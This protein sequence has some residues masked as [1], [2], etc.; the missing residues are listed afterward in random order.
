MAD[1]TTLSVPGAKF[2]VPRP[3]KRMVQVL[4]AVALTSVLVLVVLSINSMLVGKGT[5]LQGFNAWMTFM[6]R[7]DIFAIMT[8]T[9]VVSVAMIYWPAGDR[10]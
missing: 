8:L 9:A 6:R 10:R 3:L 5:W 2:L 7:P 4:S 1:K